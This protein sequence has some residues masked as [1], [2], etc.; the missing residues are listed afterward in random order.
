MLA[1]V[2]ARLRRFFGSSAYPSVFRLVMITARAV[3]PLEGTVI[4]RLGIALARSGYSVGIPDLPGI[5]EGELTPA[6]VQAAVACA[7]AT[8]DD[9]GA[10]G[11]RVALVGVSV[12][13][14]L[15]LLAAAEPTLAPRVSVV[16]CI[17][18]FSD[19][20]Q[21]MLLATTGMYRSERG[22]EPYPVPDSLWLGLERSLLALVPPLGAWL[23]SGR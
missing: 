14:T 12:G 2:D 3:P 21:V 1:M 6:T 5:A 17:A 19:L 10:R 13:G 20:A 18:P 8:A 4:R 22:L 7:T 9:P 15:A 11:A 23:T 16:V